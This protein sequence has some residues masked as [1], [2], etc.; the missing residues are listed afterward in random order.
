MIITTP[1]S[2][3]P[4]ES[5]AKGTRHRTDGRQA[6]DR[7]FLNL[8]TWRH[9][10]I[11]RY[12]HAFLDQMVE[13]GEVFSPDFNDQFEVPVGIRRVFMG[14]AVNELARRRLIRSTGSP[15][16]TTQGGRHGTY[17]EVWQLGTDRAGIDAW[18]TTH[19]IPPA[20]EP[21]PTP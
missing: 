7:A 5:K 14:A 9:H 4:D 15:R 19:P 13:L 2:P 1:A 20:P 21:I 18:K 12:Q 11:R 6:K 8:D 16:Y 10:L 17:L 3:S